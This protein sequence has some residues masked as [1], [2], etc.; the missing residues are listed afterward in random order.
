MDMLPLKAEMGLLFEAVKSKNKDLIYKWKSTEVWSTL[1]Q[2]ISAARN[3][4]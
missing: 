3:D 4:R 1:E 2:L